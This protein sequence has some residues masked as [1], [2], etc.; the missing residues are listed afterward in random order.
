MSL[1]RI[2]QTYKLRLTNLN[3]RNRSLKLGKLSARRDIDLKDLSF[4]NEESVETILQKIIAGKNVTLIPSLNPRH[5]K[6]NIIDRRLNRIYRE[7]T[8]IFEES[9]AYDLS[10]G[11]PFVEGK[12]IDGTI[13]RCPVVLFPVNLI[14]NLNGKPR[15]KLQTN[16]EDPPAFNR[17]FFLAYERFQESRIKESFWEEELSYQ[18]NWLDWVNHLYHK[19]KD[20][21]I[22]VN[23]NPRL[24][25]LKVES[26]QDYLQATMKAFGTGKIMFRPQAVLGIFPQS[27]SAILQD[28]E[29]LEKTTAHPDLQKYFHT[30]SSSHSDPA[31]FLPSA[32]TDPDEATYIREEDRYFVT[33]V[34]ATQEEVLL[35]AK[36]NQ[37][38]VLQGPPGTGKSQVIVNLIADAMAHGKRVLLVSQKRAALDVVY[39]RLA[40]LNL[41]SFAVCLHDHRQDRNSIF[42]Q[43]RQQIEDIPA[44]QQRL[45]DLNLT[46][47]EREYK[48]ISRKADQFFSQF[49]ELY[50]A[51]SQPLACGQ[52]A[53]ELYLSID[54][55]LT[56]L[57]LE[58]ISQQ[59]KDVELDRFL[60]KYERIQAYQ[61]FLSPDYVWTDRLPLHQSSHQELEQ[62]AEV[63]S[64]A[65]KHLHQLYELYIAL[66]SQQFTPSLDPL[67]NQL[68]VRLYRQ[69]QEDI[70]KEKVLKDL[71]ALSFSR[72]APDRLHQTLIKIRQALADLEDRQWLTDHDWG[73]YDK[74]QQHIDQYQSH[75][76]NPLRF[77]SLPFQRAKRFLSKIAARKNQPLTPS[78]FAEISG[79]MKVFRRIHRLYAQ[80]FS[81]AF[82]EDFPLL[83]TQAEKLAWI[84]MKLSHYDA[85]QRL[86]SKDLY[87]QFIPIFKKGKLDADHWDRTMAL[88]NK[89][90]TF[91]TVLNQHLDEWKIHF[92]PKLVEKLH[93]AIPNF[94]DYSA[95]LNQLKE[96]FHRDKNDLQQLDKLLFDLNHTEKKALSILIQYQS[97][98][99][100]P[101]IQ[102]DQIKNSVY[103]FWLEQA[104]RKFPILLRV[105]ER[106]W[107]QTL[108]EYADQL[109][110]RREK[111]TE[112]IKRRLQ[113]SLTEIIEYNRL[114][115]PITFRNIFHQVSKKKRIWSLRKLVKNSWNNGLSQLIPCWMASPEAVSAVFP[116]DK[117]F[118]D[119]VIFDEASQCFVERGLPA[120]LRAKQCIIAGDPQQLQPLNLYAVRYDNWEEDDDDDSL[121][122]ALEVES[123][124]D[125]GQTLFPSKKLA[126]HYRSLYGELVQFSNE[127][128]YENKLQMIPL[129]YPQMRYQ[130]PL[131][132]VQ[133]DGVWEK[134]HNIVE[135]N[136]TIELVLD[137]IQ[138]ADNPSIGIVTFNYPQQE[139]IKDRLE[140]T[141][142]QLA[143]TNSTLHGLLWAALSRTEEEEFK[144]LFVK[145]IENVQ[146]DER[147]VIIF[148]IGYA[149]DVKGR[150]ASR[151]GLLN[152]S[153]GENRLNVAITRAK[154]KVYVIASF[155]P[156]QLQIAQTTH[157]GPK[158]L[159][160]Y[161]GF[162]RSVHANGHTESPVYASPPDIAILKDHLYQQMITYF[163]E[164]LQLEGFYVELHTGNTAYRLD[165]AVKR[166]SEDQHYLM[167]IECE[168]PYYFRGISPKE[169]EVYRRK[170]L[171]QRGWKLYRIWARNYWLNREL[172]LK[173][174]LTELSKV[175]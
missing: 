149:P 146:G 26:F 55:E 56:I 126:W 77:I 143:E 54:P 70:N 63:I 165:L 121:H 100:V 130:P 51:L 73:D 103:F 93:T 150:L 127:H 134:N 111:V 76:G 27:D 25:D 140:E 52:S 124:L 20:Y 164:A 119:L 118:F 8:T 117:S 112:L 128:F 22:S 170:L 11:Y 16:R 101:I 153:G 109:A 91:N 172:E 87:P 145:N 108:K 166:S 58:E 104:E 68:I 171:K 110:F 115:N 9:G 102:A 53:H 64:L 89:L 75:L 82:I 162:V 123:I 175:T 147:D 30:L 19:M 37:S 14:R 41:H 86:S 32:G 174:I 132:F 97:D 114:K 90:A 62:L 48:L 33:P 131:E 47:W 13:L 160:Q 95:F 96:T 78:A 167:G 144:G 173:K 92:H 39:H 66:D 24:F 157:P 142:A 60:T 141:L 168:G 99:A 116:M 74:I 154:Q 43:I 71:E 169:R 72:A 46:K 5:E 45:R 2:L 57:P 61:D 4:L 28:Y 38:L 83:D 138:F 98:H 113:E 67:Q 18:N 161:L 6:S 81:N 84:Q 23:V 151:F 152:L 1:H 40:E 42:H 80:Y 49:E 136:K 3:Q 135:A 59:W 158:L 163:Q 34:D 15:W 65:P 50:Q 125:F 105:S 129:S 79:E 94:P 12:F 106:G 139:F 107:P 120:M 29:A 44:Y 137:L 35:A 133:V 148:S 88:I 159:K 31:P 10:V 122:V 36:R 69:I 85:F 17:T 156:E 21:D 155:S 7:L